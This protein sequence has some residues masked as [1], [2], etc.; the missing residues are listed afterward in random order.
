MQLRALSCLVP[1]P[2]EFVA[3]PPDAPV[4]WEMPEEPLSRL[5]TLADVDRIVG[6]NLSS[7]KLRV[8]SDG[9]TVPVSSYLHGGR[10]SGR[11]N[12][13]SADSVRPSRVGGL[14]AKGSTL[15]LDGLQHVW[16]PT[17]E[18]CRRL[19]FESGSPVDAS[20]FL[21]PAGGRGFRYHWDIESVLLVQTMGS[22]TWHLH[23]P[24]RPLPLA[25]EWEALSDADQERC[26][27]REPDL[28]VDLRPGQVLWI[29]RGWIHGGH[30][31]DRPSL[32][33]SF[34]FL[35]FTR[36][37][38]AMR[39][40][41]AM[42][43]R[44][45]EFDSLRHHLPMGIGSRPQA[46]RVAVADVAAALVAALPYVDTDRTAADAARGMRRDLLDAPMHSASLLSGTVTA[47]TR[48]RL[49][50][51][52]ITGVDTLPDGRVTLSVGATAITVG[53]EP[54][55][56]LAG[57]RDQETDQPWCASDMPP[58]TGEETAVR[59]VRELLRTGAARRV[60]P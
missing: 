30:T 60:T 46:L 5:L 48:V 28:A 14:L 2:A 54:G 19:S 11:S 26:R 22:K 25:H 38:L 51:E 32:H 34:G 21:T 41:Q 59:L 50:S 4:V 29:P 37:W 36:Y 55:R 17:A 53:E 56:W 39:V 57:C 6:Q 47:N 20:A 24:V 58:A 23:A 10:G 40:I 15:V 31:T 9:V 43:E 8:V 52:H 1:D 42:D 44:R 27:T 49:I 18:L 3:A 13:R 35:P 12:A 45:P 7:D 33:V 16:E